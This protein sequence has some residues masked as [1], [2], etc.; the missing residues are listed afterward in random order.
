M[1]TVSRLCSRKALAIG[2]LSLAVVPAAYAWTQFFA[3]T[4]RQ[5]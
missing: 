4:L 1:A 5:Q 3:I 2:A